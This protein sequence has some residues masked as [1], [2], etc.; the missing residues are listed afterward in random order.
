MKN[1]K[2]KKNSENK[3][4]N[5]KRVF[6]QKREKSGKMSDIPEKISNLVLIPKQK[7]E[8]DSELKKED[9]KQSEPGLLIQE[10]INIIGSA[11][12]FICISSFV[13]GNK[14]IQDAL[15]EAYQRN[16]R[17]YFL[18]A[19]ENYLDKDILSEKDIRSLENHIRFL[20]EMQGKVLIR[21]SKEFHLKCILIDPKNRKN[22]K[23]Y[24]MTCNLT[25]AVYKSPDIAV[26]LT[27]NQI[28]VIFHQFLI[29]F[30]ILA[31]GEIRSDGLGDLANPPKNLPIELPKLKSSKAGIYTTIKNQ[32]QKEAGEYESFKLKDQLIKFIQESDG[33][34]KVFAWNFDARNDSVKEI[35]LHLKKER[36]VK[37]I[38]NSKSKIKPG[39][40]TLLNSGA[41]IYGIPFFHA[42]GVIS[43]NNG[44][45]KAFIMTSNFENAGI[46][47][48]FN[49][50]IM[51][52]DE[53][54][55]LKLNYL[56]DEWCR[57]SKFKLKE[58]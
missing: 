56:F 1:T 35:L 14:K 11:Q 6:W 53:G 36:P 39:L 31:T 48:G 51:I 19:S 46:D 3:K 52:N 40:R 23:G 12:E 37:I 16:V 20:K 33:E 5:S 13:I 32:N 57:C 29:G 45:L 38:T 44:K 49:T 54:Q 34:L 4:V 47:Y 21:S 42:K 18:T 55:A 30:Y 9:F 7:D 8:E 2:G 22:R 28:D 10:L 58:E 41:E 24:V 43:K 26:K 15:I 25:G 27:G 50:G 17:I